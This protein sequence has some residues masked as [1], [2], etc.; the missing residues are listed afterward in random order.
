[1]KKVLCKY[2]IIQNRQVIYLKQNKPKIIFT[3]IWENIELSE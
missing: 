2:R 3:D 1:M